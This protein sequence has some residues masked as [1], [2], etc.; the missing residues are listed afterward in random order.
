[1][2][3][4][5]GLTYFLDNENAPVVPGGALWSAPLP[6]SRGAFSREPR[7]PDRPPVT[8]GDYFTA[9]RDF[10]EIDNFEKF[11]AA[12]SRRLDREISLEEIT[13]IRVY[14]AKHGEFYHPARIEPLLPSSHAP[15]PR[16][17]LNA[18]VSE[19]GK[20]TLRAEYAHLA[21]L[22]R[23]FPFKYIPK[24]FHQGEGR[25]PADRT[26]PMFLGQWLDGF[27]EF[28]ISRDRAA[29]VRG[30]TVWDGRPEPVFLTEEQ[31]FDLYRQTAVILT[32]YFNLETLERIFSWHHA[33]GDFV[34][35]PRPGGVDVRLI[36][37]RRY[38]PMFETER[39]PG[40]EGPDRGAD[41]VKTLSALLLFLLSISIRTRVDR[42]DGVG[43]IAWADDL[44]V[45]AT[46]TGFFQALGDVSRIH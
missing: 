42:L 45:H 38:A 36:T 41:P 29:G 44:A 10:L 18:A 24:V 9:A 33:A 22:N 11:R 6:M 28:H 13:G 3:T 12:C 20:K 30:V 17:V 43:E 34:A 26:I 31:T 37:V 1:M 32:S 15:S 46:L 25:S 21:R 39:E 40:A 16:F 19:T 4:A 7:E 14:L 35:R 8:R 2:A 5:P 27:H 23:D